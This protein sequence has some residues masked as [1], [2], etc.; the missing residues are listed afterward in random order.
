MKV[1]Y[2]LV[3]ILLVL[4]G[5]NA[6]AQWTQT[7]GPYTTGKVNCFATDGTTL[8]TG[9]QNSGIFSSS[10]FGANWNLSANGYGI[11]AFHTLMLNGANIFAAGDNGLYLSTNNG[12]S[13][14]VILGG[15]FYSG[16][17]IVELGTTLIASNNGGIYR[18]TNN[19][20]SWNQQSSTLINATLVVVG[21]D[22]LAATTSGV[23]ISTNDGVTWTLANGT[24]TSVI[25]MKTSGSSIYAGTNGS[26]VYVSTDNGTTW[27]AKN[28]GLSGLSL[29]VNCLAFDG[30]DLYA[31][32]GGAGVYKTTDFG[33]TWN[34][35]NTGITTAFV[36][37][38]QVMGANIFIGTNATGVEVTGNFGTSWATSNNGLITSDIRAIMLDGS[39]NLYAGGNGSGAFL[40]GSNGAN[41]SGVN[42]GLTNSTVQAFAMMGSTT[43]VGTAAGVFYTTNNGAS[44]TAVNTGLSN[45]NIQQLVVIGTN[46]FAATFG[47]GVFLS[48]NSG[49]SWTA[50]NSGLTSSNINSLAVIGTS[51]FAAT[52]TKGVFVSTNNGT[53][54]TTVN[55]GLPAAWVYSI[56][57]RGTNLFAIV[58]SGNTVYLSTNS[59]ASWTLSNIGIVGSVYELITSGANI[60][61]I[62]Y[63]VNISTNNGASWTDISTGL[64]SINHYGFAVNGNNV[65]VG[66]TGLGVWTRHL[67][68]ILCSVNPPVMS[69]SS[70]ATICSGQ[71]LNIPLTNTGVA[72]TYGWV[73]ASNSQ[74]TGASTT[75]QST[76]TINNTLVNTSSLSSTSV[77][78]TVTPTGVS[79]GC[80]GTPQTVTITLN[81]TPLMTSSSALTICSGQSVG[82]ALTSSVASNF[83]WM[84]SSNPNTSGQSLT[85]Q[86]ATT[87]NDAITNNSLTPQTVTYTV[88]PTSVGGT[89]AGTPQTVT[90]TVNPKPVMTSTSAV[91]ICS[92]ATVNIPLT[93]NVQ[94]NYTWIAAANANTT[95]ASTTI[96]S[97]STLSNTIVNTSAVAQNVVY[98]VTP[99]A[100]VGGCAGSQ[101]VTVT[102]N[103]APVMTSGTSAT[104]CSGGA[105]S[106]PLTTNIA[107][108]FVWSAT[109]DNPNT[110]GE[111][112]TSQTTATLNNTIVNN[113][114]SSQVV[115]YTVT[116]ASVSGGCA[117]ASQ[118]VS[119]TVNPVPSMISNA[120]ATI[121]SGD[122]VNLSLSAS[123][124][125][126]FSWMAATNS[127]VS[128][129]STTAQATGTISDL[130]TNNSNSTQ[131]V[132]YT[133]TP[134]ATILGGCAGTPQTV[135][136]TVNPVPSMTS[137]SSATI[138]GGGTVNIP[139]TSNVASSYIWSAANNVNTSGEDVSSQSSNTLSNTITNSTSVAQNVVYT[140]TPTSTAGSCAG[141][142][143][144]VNVT[145]NPSPI[146]ISSANATIC[147]GGTVNIPLI[148]TT[149]AT[150][151]WIA[152][153]NVNTTGESLTAQAGNS[154][155]NTIAN[156]SATVQD[157]IY[158][159]T[160]TSG[161]G[162]VGGGQIVSVVVNP[163][164]N[165][166]F[167]YASGTYCQSG[168]DP[169]AVITGVS[170]G[171]FS[172]TA[173]L[174]FLNTN[175]GLINLAASAPGTYTVTYNTNS[176]C[177]N[178]STFNITI[179][180]APMASFTYPSAAYCSSAA[181]PSPVMGSGA[182]TGVFSANPTGLAFVSTATGEVNLSGSVPGTYTVTNTI[183]ASGGC[184]SVN[185]TAV[186]TVNP[187]PVVSFSGL[188]ASYYYNDAP[189]SLVGVPTGGTFSGTGVSGSLFSPSVA[190]GG[191]FPITYSYTDGN[192]CSNTSAIFS[193]TVLAQPAPPSICEVT[194]DD[195]SKFN[196][197]YWEKTRYTKV[198]SFIVYRETGA[199]YQRIGAI[200][201]TSFSAFTDTVRHKYFPNTGDPNAGTYRYKLQIRDSLGNYSP[202]SPYHNTIYIN[203]TFG[204]FTW[205]AYEIEGQPV[206][207][208][209]ATLISYDLWRKDSTNGTWN[210]VNSVAGSQL[211]QTDVGWNATLQHLG[212]WRVQTNWDIQCNPTRTLINTSHSNI[213][214]PAGT[215]TAGITELE[216]NNAISVFPN[217]AM[218]QVT[219]QIGTETKDLTIRIYNMVG[220]VVYQSTVTNQKTVIDVSPFAKGVYTI[221]VANTSAKGFKKL[222]VQ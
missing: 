58:G 183:A 182:S 79:G 75:A 160:P 150:Y 6:Q 38:V 69:S 147:S 88:T 134:T 169:S 146:M 175:N 56:A 110:T 214:H 207:L 149:P 5:L 86:S 153:D 83:S 178:S 215:V 93:S 168:N 43:F 49:A 128:G 154:L 98:T 16:S 14:S 65:F 10:N 33:T 177:S 3:L 31:G 158:T 8:F 122:P 37:A 219:V 218:D 121:C 188:N 4:F 222:I 127:N 133:V 96:Q 159:V 161:A 170:G 32:T 132:M 68:E 142:A 200:G 39:G 181:N 13:W 118:S 171:S 47:G 179:T 186:I 208:P 113:S 44:W 15:G 166:G 195:S 60:F 189:A 12:S 212:S 30:T 151:S 87:L 190:G 156:N 29:T 11:Y 114:N 185:A 103:P 64:P 2:K 197:I 90:I 59:G 41:W 1:S 76:S 28:T 136:V 209:S 7:N 21:S 50:V 131:N 135:T 22:Y 164:D 23:Y 73:A 82:L 101:T 19:G 36:N 203:Q 92:G 67:D 66:N 109:L 213:R 137:A 35:V 217:P 204:T 210:I 130:L 173:G 221:E 63:G 138:C 157:V 74:V 72:A 99:T 120:T 48:T 184:A 125:S 102:V 78:Y 211:T 51:L 55:T 9:T 165:A 80:A 140:V 220:Q 20:A 119:V 94:S 17:S 123:I 145:V 27:T 202:M 116:P 108:N 194:V 25:A 162:C 62:G 54:W 152:T 198:D 117:G 107:S 42:I 148:S 97:P 155:I 71:S 129:E 34:A 115:Y 196:I 124:S 112:L 52:D 24:Q 191:T 89:C 70:A 40:T 144:T 206:P 26:G 104:I 106:I 81:P 95:G 193:T 105:V 205:N 45:T 192:G 167:S 126:S 216:L 57:A 84:A 91:T 180:P 18:S 163:L 77:V 201:D 174:V 111:S 85:P 100:V 187:L 46:L 143:Q 199:G 53:S 139:L 141:M 176:T 172:A 61:A